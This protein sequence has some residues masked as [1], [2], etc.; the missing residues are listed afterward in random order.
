MKIKKST[1]KIWAVVVVKRDILI[2]ISLFRD[3]EIAE[4]EYKRQKIKSNPEDD[5]IQLL[6]VPIEERDR[7][8]SN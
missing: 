8:F 3:E 2:G 5:D 6:H 7:V 1:E 4:Q